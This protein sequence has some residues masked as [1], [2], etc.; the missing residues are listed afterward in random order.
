MVIAV[1]EFCP[2]RWQPNATSVIVVVSNLGSEDV[3]KEVVSVSMEAHDASK[4]GDARDGLAG[5]VMG[6]V[7]MPWIVN[8]RRSGLL[9]GFFGI[10]RKAETENT[11]P[12]A[13][14]EGLPCTNSGLNRA[15]RR[16]KTFTCD[17]A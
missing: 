11:S 8:E 17:W 1:I 15:N 13:R 12:K 6:G 14:G 10:F 7:L 4:C 3:A 5:V 16:S 9:A 2:L